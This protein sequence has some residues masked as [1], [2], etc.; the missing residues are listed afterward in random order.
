MTKISDDYLE[1]FVGNCI[2]DYDD[3]S[4]IKLT[5]EQATEDT[6][7]C[8]EDNEYE[9]TDSQ[10]DDLLGY[11]EDDFSYYKNKALERI[12]DEF[13]NKLEEVY[14]DYSSDLDRVEILKTLIR[15]ANDFCIND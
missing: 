3:R 6:L 4:L 10:K 13:Y 5:L 15:I 2:Y 1:K 8:L 11:I 7:R 14:I 12:K 9:L